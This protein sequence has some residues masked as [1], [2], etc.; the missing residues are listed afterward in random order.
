MIGI[1]SRDRDVGEMRGCE[2]PSLIRSTVTRKNMPPES[3]LTS[4]GWSL[5]GLLTQGDRFREIPRI[6]VSDKNLDAT[7]RDHES[8]GLPLVIEG[9]HEH[10]AWPTAMFDIQWLRDNLK[11]RELGRLVS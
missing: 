5:N 7:I 11:Q 9:M 1:H 2:L 4:A 3:L 6:S 8:S 10:Q